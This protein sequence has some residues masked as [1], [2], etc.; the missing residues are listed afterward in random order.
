[1]VWNIVR[2]SPAFQANFELLDF[3]IYKFLQFIVGGNFGIRV[4]VWVTK[5]VLELQLTLWLWDIRMSI[6]RLLMRMM[7]HTC[8]RAKNDQRY[9]KLK[10]QTFLT[11]VYYKL[12]FV[13]SDIASLFLFVGKALC[14]VTKKGCIW[15]HLFD[16]CFLVYVKDQP[17]PPSP[18]LSNLANLL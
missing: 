11:V 14:D 9:L 8:I 5:L 18:S 15:D 1:M 7:E 10:W 17:L 12:F 2:Y 16:S 4:R 6:C 3:I 13:L